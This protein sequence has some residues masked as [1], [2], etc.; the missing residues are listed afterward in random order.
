MIFAGGTCDGSLKISGSFASRPKLFTSLFRELVNDAL[1]SFIV[2]VVVVVGES[3][4]NVN[5]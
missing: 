1:F 3:A 5:R 2:V 4:R